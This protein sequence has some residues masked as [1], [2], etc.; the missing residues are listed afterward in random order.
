MLPGSRCETCSSTE[1]LQSAQTDAVDFHRQE[2]VSF[3]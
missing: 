3:A 2:R 1:G